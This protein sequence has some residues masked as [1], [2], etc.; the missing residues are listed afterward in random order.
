M[1]TNKG[2]VHL[3]VQQGVRRQ[4]YFA[5]IPVAHQIDN[6]VCA[7]LYYT[8]MQENI[9][10]RLHDS[11]PGMCAVHATLPTYFFLHFCTKG[12]LDKQNS[13]LSMGNFLIYCIWHPKN[14]KLW[15]LPPT[16][17]LPCQ[18]HDPISWAERV[19]L[20]LPKWCKR[21]RSFT[22]SWYTVDHNVP[23]KPLCDAD[24]VHHSVGCW[25]LH[26]RLMLA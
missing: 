15:H 20:N 11:R 22:S 13:L 2:C 25:L 7:V 6:V 3:N 21:L 10:A 16:W 12:V 23:I 14:S 4:N 24:V 26:A 1:G 9:W 8:Y 19:T 17:C 5:A 18:C